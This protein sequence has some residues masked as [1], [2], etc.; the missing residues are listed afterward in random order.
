MP[1]ASH[2]SAKLDGRPIEAVLIDAGGVIV[3]PNW[4]RIAELLAERGV[5][6][7]A[8]ALIAA[9]P[10][11][12]HA[13][14]LQGRIGQTSDAIRRETYLASVMAAGGLDGDGA[15]VAEASGQMEREHLERGIW[16]V[17]PEGTADALARL[18]ASGLKVAL[19]SNAERSFR[20]KLAELGLAAA[21]DHLGISAEI[22][23]E[24][25]DPRFFTA[26]LD[27]IGVDASRALHVGD[28]YEVDVVGARSAGLAA[29]LVDPADL[30]ADV[31]V[32]RIRSLSELP[33][34][35]TLA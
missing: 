21:F 28:L 29:V 18:R 25:P 8:H 1:V 17:V 30:Y 11:A 24:K 35:L 10:H 32:V 6:V 20:H 27:A 13:L 2:V 22:G 7:E 9:E 26:I 23:I 5:E 33:A 34:V 16:E 19:A 15:A 12:K 3:D 14:D 31:N 4:H